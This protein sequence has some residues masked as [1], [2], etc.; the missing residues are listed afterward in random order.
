VR[1]RQA[2]VLVVGLAEPEIQP[3]IRAAGH[4]IRAVRN[5]DAALAALD[6]EPAD[7]VIVDREPA[8]LDVPG[9][10]RRLRADHRA[11]EAWLLALTIAAH[12]VTADAALDAGADD[13]L[14]RPFT[15]SELLARARAGL[16]AAQQ[17]A[18]DA[19][20]RALMVNVPGAIYRSAWHANFTLEL[21]SDEIERISGYPAAN[22]IA[23][24]KR[25]LWSIVHPDDRPKMQE[26]LNQARDENE[27]F[28][29]EYRIVRADGEVRWVLDRGQL[30]AGAGGR[31]WCDGAIFD[32]TERRAAEEAARHREIER[33]RNEELH[34]SRARIVEAADNARRRIERD[35]HDGA[36][37]RLVALALE[38]RMARARVDKDPASAPP[39]LER[40]GKELTEASAD[41][42]ELARGIHPAVLTERGL[43]P[44]I[45]ALVSRAP[46][47]VEVIGLPADRLPPATEATAY[48]TVA[49]ALTNVA[50]YAG[51]SHATVRMAREDGVLAV[52]VRDDGVGGARAT[53]GSGLSGLADR[54]GAADGT[55]SV[56]SPPGDGTV[57]RAE[58]PLAG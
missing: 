22:F 54:V 29:L 41:L 31:L 6:E 20:V 2:G 52:E 35:L 44:A 19:I 1:R 46:V 40:I 10:C 15:R 33:A 13:Y 50:K 34:A 4:A 24:K 9:V 8:G 49:E 23:S 45:D 36:Q 27:P 17:R 55:L 12:K 58:L 21:I 53:P 39:F 18:D 7:L 3:W 38:V 16:R 30:V 43:A 56:V 51:A 11:D 5:V 26:E 47:P 37:Q 32:V 28:G 14:H 42:R 25:T 48:F 57:V